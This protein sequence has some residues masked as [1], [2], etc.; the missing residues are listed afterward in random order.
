VGQAE[1]LGLTTQ[2]SEVANPDALEPAFSSMSSNGA[3][4]VFVGASSMLFNE[5]RRLASLAEAHHL[6][7]TVF[8]SEMVRAGGLMFYGSSFVTTFRRAAY[9]VDKILR[10]AKPADLPVERPTKFE[11]AINLKTAAALNV[12]VSPTLL[13]RADEVIE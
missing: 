7:T 9:Y 13:A 2:F 8:D 5:R 6:P 3:S 4:G 1:K 12:T 10:G 11:L